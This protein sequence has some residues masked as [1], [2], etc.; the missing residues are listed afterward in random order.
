[1]IANNGLRHQ[2]QVLA[3]VLDG[4]TGEVLRDAVPKVAADED[5]NP[6]AMTPIRD[7]LAGATT[8]GTAARAFEGFPFWVY[9]V[10]GKTGTA[11][12][13]GKA[14]FSLFAGFGPAFDPQYAVATVLEEAGFGSDAAAP[15]TRKMFEYLS[16]LI[17]VPRAPLATE[18]LPLS[19][20]LEVLA[21][22]DE[23]AREAAEAEAEATGE[24]AEVALADL[25]GEP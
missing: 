4:E 18:A 3:E 23:I 24:V 15:A 2:P 10:S 8:L 7:G 5:F 1:M 21:I 12:V 14:D 11:Q 22:L 19:V 6:V 9:P 17:E 20:D 13:A 25:P 16:G